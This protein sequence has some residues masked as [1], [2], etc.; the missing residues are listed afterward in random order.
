MDGADGKIS[1]DPAEGF[2]PADLARPLA[3]PENAIAV[4]CAR[5][6]ITPAPH[7]DRVIVELSLTI[8]L[9]AGDRIGVLEMSGGQ[10]RYRLIKGDLRDAAEGREIGDRLD[11]FQ[12]RVQSEPT[13]NP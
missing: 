8:N 4:Q 5:E 1:L 12:A 10:F 13:A 9:Q 7:D 11:L 6:T 3:K 2:D